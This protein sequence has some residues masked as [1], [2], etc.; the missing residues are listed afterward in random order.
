MRGSEPDVLSPREAY[1]RWAESYGG[2]NAV[3]TLEQAAV[4]AVS[5]AHSP[6]RLLDVGCGVGRRIR[7]CEPQPWWVVGLDLTPAMLRVARQ[8]APRLRL[9]NADV[10]QL[11]VRDQAFDLVWCR[12][13]LGHVRDLETAYRELFRVSRPGASLIVSDFHPA[14]AQAGHSRTFRDRAGRLHAVEHQAHSLEAH[15]QAAQTAGFTPGPLNEQEVGPAVRGFYD[16]A[17][18]GHRYQKD[19]G[20]P[21]VFAWRFSHPGRSPEAP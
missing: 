18:A 2:E 1:A 6:G 7:E 8:A 20:L 17:G 5:P 19:L 10:L 4:R 16:A 3:T 9:I 13:V 21:L 14:A 12:L 15:R 11:P